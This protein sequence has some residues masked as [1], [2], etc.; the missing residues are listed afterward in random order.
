MARDQDR[1]R[2]QLDRAR[3]LQDRAA[4]QAILDEVAAAVAA[5]EQRVANRRAGVPTPRYPAAL[6]V[7]ERKDEIAAAIAAH[8][9]VIV[10]GE[11]GSGKSTQLPKICLEVGRGVR[12]MIGHTQPRRLAARA[13]AER[14]AEELDSAVGGA[15]G[16]AVRFT[17]RV[18]QQ[19]LIKVMTDGILLNEI[20]RDRLLT[21]YDTIIVDEA[22]ERSLNIDFILGYLKQL[23]P[24]RPDLKVIVTSATI[25][26][27]RFAR[28]FGGAPIVEVSGRTYPVEIRYRPLVDPD[29][30]PGAD[31]GAD[32]TAGD[33]PGDDAEEIDQIQAIGNAVSE[34]VAEGPGD[35]LVFLSGERE[36][37]D[38]AEALAALALP[39]TELLPLY[40]RLSA[41]EQHRV[42]E[43]HPG[44]RIVLATNVAETSL[45]V[46]GILAVVDPGTARISRYSHRTKV[47]RLPIEPVSQASANQ[48]AGRCGRVAP[49]VCIR[50]Y[51]E[52][53][54]RSRPE[55]T[56][57]EI[58]RTNLASVILQ[59]AALGLGDV[60]R[61]PFVD[62]PDA[63]SIK[64]GIALLEELGALDPAAK[65]PK[66]R[67]T[68]LGRR[69]AQ[70]P[71]DPRLG[72][73]VLE[74]EA[75]GCLEEVMVIAAALSI[76][77]PR[78]RPLDKQAAAAE[79][80]ARFADKESDFLSYLKLWDY[81]QERQD[82]L[83]SNQF[84]KL[85]RA[86]FLNFLRIREWQDIHGQLRQVM[87]NLNGRKADA[88]PIEDDTK[89]RKAIH[90]SL[91]AGLLSHIGLKSGPRDE[92]QGARNARFAIAP[93]S[94]LF[95][96]GAGWVMAAELVETTRL[97]ARVVARIEPEWAERLGAHLV[98]RSYSEPHWD[99]KRGEAM[100]Y[101]R[102][103]LYGLPIVSSRRV[104]YNRVDP[105]AARD[106]FIRMA[107]VE[108]DWRTPHPFWAE[109]RK[110]VEE[111]RALARKVRRTDV[112]V[113]DEVLIDFYDKRIG[114]E[115]T[116]ARTF[117]A[118]W[119]KERVK[120]PDL[121]R[122]TRELLINPAVGTLDAG[123]YP[124]VWRYRNLDLRL[125]YSFDPGAE[126][127]GVTVRIP[128]PV[129][130]QIDAGPFEWQVP[131][132]RLETVA[133]LIR[134]LP[135]EVRRSFVPVPDYAREAL[136]RIT[137]E[138]GPLPDTLARE[139]GRL[140]GDPIPP[141]SWE[142][143]RVPPHLRMRF[144]VEDEAGRVLAAGRDL[145]ALQEQLA[146]RAEAGL[147]VAA[148]TF[149][150][151]GLRSWG[152]I[153]T[154]PRE[155]DVI[156]AGFRRRAYPAL[157][158]QGDSVAVRVFPTPEEQDREMWAGTRRLLLLSLPNPT[159]AAERR[160]SND[161]Q[162]ALARSPYPKVADL[163]DDCV[164]CAVDQLLG[165]LGG[166]VWNESAFT[167][168]RT[169]VSHA[170]TETVVYVVTVVAG[171]L[172]IANGIDVRLS[173]LRAPSLAPSITDIERQL[174]RLVSPGFVAAT[175]V[176][177]LAD[178]MRYLEGIELRL[179]K[180]PT[181]ADRDFDNLRRVQRLE[182]RY[183]ELLGALGPNA[184][185]EA[186]AI[187]W[188][189][190]ELRI[191]YFAQGLG[192]SQPVSEKRILREI[193][194]WWSQA[195]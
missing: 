97:W 16:Y 54:F 108:G 107:L 106:L 134:T 1:L 20:Q 180:L 85:C 164:L 59:M 154:L 125:S 161:T 103:T 95:K 146:E 57:P 117:D 28:H 25:D 99:A 131:G 193:D 192:T 119:K 172:A 151:D 65:N 29:A 163:F 144:L 94:V 191:S 43:P 72:R 100:A 11:T 168:L 90:Q 156:W 9:V 155:V 169:G 104:S 55:F 5:A 128:L 15:V 68:P 160:L 140:T 135:K 142:W 190:E 40:A 44:R 126:W 46:P 58:V 45:T 21:A 187:G 170:L 114:A 92:Y 10:A 137:P 78:E 30:P 75:N 159:R 23:L 182:R 67:L 166:P 113:D 33:D 133:A 121:L 56:E 123:A 70:L 19:T 189:I 2:R 71:L 183:G 153:G 69:L 178:L 76:Q 141:G 127:D 171:I 96:S 167:A 17:D 111:V 184:D 102:V 88:A 31:A 48:R 175:G 6:P 87:R 64:D 41:A 73:M 105:S 188:M 24:R 13:V 36:I 145:R 53:D 27:E 18:S 181:G 77:D 177:R 52:T 63:R 149:E 50:L 7:S 132:L 51:S 124:D 139:L 112:L 120:H 186:E 66:K 3:G 62:A 158:D 37:R 8:Q 12:G 179:D 147:A 162:L 42:F 157:V 47:Q 26:T 138:D 185:E 101:E 143:E 22:H 81:L 109:N 150:R 116:S 110:L 176:R 49:G 84:R 195:G 173:K 118:W 38:T 130:D 194:R 39:D 129:L 34:L 86:E 91:L 61:F 165:D 35:I 115:V 4:R 148:S 98:K 14:V 82:A 60:A 136:K 174:A 79:A 74:A 152:G 89:R 80:H 32:G 83:S 122:F 93:G